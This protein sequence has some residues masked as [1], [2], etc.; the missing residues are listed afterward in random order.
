VSVLSREFKYEE[1]KKTQIGKKEEKKKELSLCLLAF[2][3]HEKN[4]TL[5]R[6]CNATNYTLTHLHTLILLFC[7]QN[8]YLIYTRTQNRDTKREREREIETLE[9][10]KNRR[11][12]RIIQSR[13]RS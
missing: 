6:L 3:F 9:I 10:S 1:L 8:I 2:S 4:T 7:A 12:E 5:T 13:A 11:R